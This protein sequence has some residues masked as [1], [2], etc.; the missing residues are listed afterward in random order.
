MKSNRCYGSRWWCFM[1]Y[2]Y[3]AKKY[4]EY[5]S[6]QTYRQVHNEY[7]CEYPWNEDITLF[8]K[9]K[10]DF[11]SCQHKTFRAAL[12]LEPMQISNIYA[13]RAMIQ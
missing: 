12:S 7:V 2:L 9:I 11:M 3:V 8:I 13:S 10:Y 6:T 4:E 1:Y 5:V